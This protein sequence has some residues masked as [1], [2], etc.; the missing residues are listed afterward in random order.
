VRQATIAP[1]PASRVDA[2]WA[3]FACWPIERACYGDPWDRYRG[4]RKKSTLA[5]AFSRS[6]CAAT[7]H[8]PHGS[9]PSFTS[10][11]VPPRNPCDGG[12][13]CR[14]DQVGAANHT[15]SHRVECPAVGALGR[16]IAE[17]PSISAHRRGRWPSRRRSVGDGFSTGIGARAI[18]RTR[19]KAGLSRPQGRAATLGRDGS[20]RTAA[21][22]ELN[23]SRETLSS[24]IGA[25]HSGACG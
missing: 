15:R 11:A 4:V 21:S 20:D 5:G 17:C 7:G 2:L 23:V 14:R 18:R 3:V 16:F 8:A 13:R 25:A 22:A 10:L 19:K 12:S 1:C 24:G 9:M 6:R